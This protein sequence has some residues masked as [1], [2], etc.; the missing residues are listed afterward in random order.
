[1]VDEDVRKTVVITKTRFFEWNIMPFKLKNAT[2]TFSK[3]MAKLFKEWSEQFKFFF[4]DDVNVHN[5][6]WNERLEHLKLVF[7]RL[8]FVKLKLNLGKC[9]FG[10]R[11]IVFLGH[12]V[13]EQG[14]R[15]DPTKVCV[16]FNF[17][18]PSSIMNVWAFLGFTR[19]YRTFI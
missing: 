4:V 11:E 10:V 16:V 18:I 6:D 17:L 14:S 1:M 7:E 3:A 12:G 19:Y 2:N 9:C 13:D 8:R 15:L 5:S